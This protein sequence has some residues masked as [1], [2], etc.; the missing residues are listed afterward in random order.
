MGE[1][2]GLPG[3]PQPI[4][5]DFDD[6]WGEYTING[7]TFAVEAW[8]A[9]DQIG[10]IADRHSKSQNACQECGALT[11]PVEPD[12]SCGCGSKKFRMSLPL[13]KDVQELLRREYGCERVS[14]GAAAAFYAA[15]LQVTEAAKK[16][17]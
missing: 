3:R 17:S 2:S 12:Q 1:T 16:K 4:A 13:L 8:T 5:L 7:K 11:G 10:A 15:V 9:L 14:N 6:C